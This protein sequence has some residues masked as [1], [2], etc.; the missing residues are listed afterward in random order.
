MDND[1]VDKDGTTR[2]TKGKR[3]GIHAVLGA[4]DGGT[5]TPTFDS[6][7][8]RFTF[9]GGDY[10][11]LGINRDVNN[12]IDKMGSIQ[13]ETYVAYVNPLNYTLGAADYST[14]IR[15]QNGPYL[16]FRVYD[17][18][19]SIIWVAHDGVN[20]ESCTTSGGV[21]PSGKSY[22]VALV[23]RIN[24]QTIYVNDVS[25]VTTASTTRD[26]S[27]PN[28]NAY[29]GSTGAGSSHLLKNNTGLALFAYWQ[30]ALTATQIKH[31]YSALQREKR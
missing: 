15:K 10:M 17:G 2:I 13:E 30:Q 31:L 12:I 21:I 27:S 26:G 20:T 9:D 25:V 14:F 22:V 8:L 6:A 1:T 18:A 16:Y 5:T 29:I 24:G 23:R 3:N 4:G 11:N 28:S 7:K 19:G